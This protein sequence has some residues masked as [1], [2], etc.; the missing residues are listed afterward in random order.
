MEDQRFEMWKA[1]VELHLEAMVKKSIMELP[2]YN[3]R[4][5]YNRNVKPIVTAERII[6]RAYQK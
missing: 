6:R 4:R 5:D 3:I 1:K 2:H